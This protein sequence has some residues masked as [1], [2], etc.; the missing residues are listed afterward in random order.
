MLAIVACGALS[1]HGQLSR[2]LLATRFA[3][4]PL[5]CLACSTTRETRTAPFFHRE[6]CA[7]KR[8]PLSASSQKA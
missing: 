2:A 4:G 1:L 7:R 5:P 6:R 3:S 8:E